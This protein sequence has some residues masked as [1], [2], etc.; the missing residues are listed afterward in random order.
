MS[1]FK[2]I[3]RVL[4]IFSSPEISTCVPKVSFTVPLI[5]P[6]TTSGWS[7]RKISLESLVAHRTLKISSSFSPEDY[8]SN[9][10][11]DGRQRHPNDG[12]VPPAAALA[13]RGGTKRKSRRSQ[14]HYGHRPSWI[15]AL[16]NQ[17]SITD[18]STFRLWI[19]SVFKNK[20]VAVQR[21]YHNPMVFDLVLANKKMSKSNGLCLGCC[22]HSH[23]EFTY[24]DRKENIFERDR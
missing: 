16:N 21:K 12:S 8:C 20:I 15:R 7:S 6:T 3:H 17:R 11:V 5:R 9:G 23:Y 18:L 19:N 22:R 14:W 13:K 1:F 24:L 4:R 2:E 10:A